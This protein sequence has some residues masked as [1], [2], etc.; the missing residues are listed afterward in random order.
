MNLHD[1]QT[2][3]LVV[4]AAALDANLRAMALISVGPTHAV[5]DAGLKS[6]GMG[7]RRPDDRGRPGVVLL[8]RAHHLRPK[9]HP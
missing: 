1:L 7:P 9:G 2:P 6:L 8:R 4:D 3:A 5:P